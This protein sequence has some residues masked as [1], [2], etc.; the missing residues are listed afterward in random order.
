MMI[1]CRLIGFVGLW[2]MF[3]IVMVSDDEVVI[4]FVLLVV[5]G[6]GWVFEVFIKVI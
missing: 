6:N 4:V 2:F 3:M 1:G 5:K